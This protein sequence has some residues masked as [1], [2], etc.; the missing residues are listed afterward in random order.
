[1]R[2]PEHAGDSNWNMDYEVSTKWLS[3]AKIHGISCALSL[4]TR[5]ISLP[6]RGH[7]QEAGSLASP[8][9]GVGEL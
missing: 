9:A 5:T 6:Q 7:N 2:V 8:A 4:S 3:S 1:M